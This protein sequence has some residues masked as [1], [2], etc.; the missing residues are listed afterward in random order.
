MSSSKFFNHIYIV[1][2][3]IKKISLFFFIGV[4]INIV[5][6]KWLKL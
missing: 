3:E 5:Y 6:V 1:V 4:N 2:K